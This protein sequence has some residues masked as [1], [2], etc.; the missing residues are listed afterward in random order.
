[1]PATLRQRLTRRV[2]YTPEEVQL[3]VA[4]ILR[5]TT[6]AGQVEQAM[7]D[8]LAL[9]RERGDKAMAAA[10]QQTLRRMKIKDDL[11]DKALIERWQG[12]LKKG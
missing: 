1:M 9:A 10:V 2:L 12:Y 6:D 11:I 7:L 3:M 8:V 5:G 4:A